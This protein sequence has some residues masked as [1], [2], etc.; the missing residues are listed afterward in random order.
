V[1]KQT[2]PA[3]AAFSALVAAWNE[4]RNLNQHLLS[5]K[6]LA[7][8]DCDLIISAGGTDGSYGI[9]KRFECSNVK[10]L[11]QAPGQG[12]QR[13]LYTCLK[14]A[15][16]E[17]LYFTDTDCQYDA[18]VIDGL[19]FPLSAR[20]HM[21]STGGCRPRASQTSNSFVQYQACQ[22]F[23][24]YKKERRH[25]GLLGRNFAI[26]RSALDSVGGLHST[27]P[28]GTDYFLDMRLRASG[29]PIAY[30]GASQVTTKYPEDFREYLTHARR[31]IKNPLLWEPKTKFPGFAVALALALALLS[32]PT[33]IFTQRSTCFRLWA[34]LAGAV[35]CRRLQV[36]A[37][38]RSRGLPVSPSMLVK[39][40]LYVAL[41]QLAVVAA[42][43]DVV[44]PRN[45]M[46]W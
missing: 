1:T 37:Y 11:R 29:I 39:F 6:A 43:S 45:R 9:A 34:I 25:R 40:P 4:E 20:S 3:P 44:T 5:F 21:V 17:F 19:L 42:A 36:I 30:V 33:L 7:R 35:L 38:S 26:T 23:A 46:R 2:E 14:Y 28:T 32:G 10:V 12:K 13:A 18:E 15:S 27:A 24:F 41:E 22:D 16:H 31:W 8:P